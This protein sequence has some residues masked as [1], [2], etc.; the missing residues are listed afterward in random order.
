VFV[1]CSQPALEMVGKSLGHIFPGSRA[2]VLRRDLSKTNGLA[3]LRT[4]H[5]CRTPFHLVFLDPPYEKKLAEMALTV[6]EKTGLVNPGGIVVAE[7]RSKTV[8]PEQVG[9]LTL[10]RRRLYG[11]TALWLYQRNKDEPEP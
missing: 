3:S 1:D 9:R 6:V 10:Q 4:H 7:E 5:L 2:A 11:E 8:L